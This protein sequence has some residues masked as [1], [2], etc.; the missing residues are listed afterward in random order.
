MTV[1]VA[2]QF[3]ANAV[4]PPAEIVTI[5]KA[6]IGCSTMCM[7]AELCCI[8]AGCSSSNVPIKI[9]KEREK[10]RKT[11]V[12]SISNLYVHDSMISSF[13]LKNDELHFYVAVEMK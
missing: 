9:Q 11:D 13:R 3:I 4:P 7:L 5:A 1:T 8:A 6:N 10:E 2:I 12:N